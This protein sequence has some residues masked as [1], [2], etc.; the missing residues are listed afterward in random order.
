MVRLRQWAWM[1]WL[2][3]VLVCFPGRGSGA[4]APQ[5]L[6]LEVSQD[7]DYD[8]NTTQQ[9]HN[10]VADAIIFANQGSLV[11]TQNF[12]AQYNI[13]PKGPL[14]FQVKYHLFNNFHTRASNVDTLMHTV[15]ISPSSLLGIYRNMKFSLP[16][17]FNYTDVQADKYFTSF[18]INPTF[19]H[20]F[21]KTM[22]YALEMRLMRRYGWAPQ[23]FPEL[24]DYTSRNIGGSAGWYYFLD[25]GGY[26]QARFSYDYVGAV[27][28]NIDNSRYRLLLSGE[29]P[30]TKRL[31]GLLYAEAGIGA[32]D[33]GF[34]NFS[35]LY[36]Y[37]KRRDKFITF[38][39]IDLPPEN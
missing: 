19:F 4:E 32:H 14:D 25:N 13:N 15:T 22:G 39:A 10:S 24:Y 38:G 20:R 34:Q 33:H 26:L 31:N 7:V 3:L 35:T 16:C 12:R 17:V 2:V 6:R 37:P 8:T 5:K 30:F 18:S 1:A 29:Y 21:S 11:L 23:F 36:T 28:N 27:G 9:S